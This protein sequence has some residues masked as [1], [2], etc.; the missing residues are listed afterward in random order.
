VDRAA[1][2]T[3]APRKNGDKF[4]TQRDGPQDEQLAPNIA[5]LAAHGPCLFPCPLARL[6]RIPRGSAG[7]RIAIGRR[8]PGTRL[9]GSAGLRKSIERR[10]H[11][12]FLNWI[13]GGRSRRGAVRGSSRSRD[14]QGGPGGLDPFQCKNNISNVMERR[15]VTLSSKMKGRSSK[16]EGAGDHSIGM[17]RCRDR[18]LASPSRDRRIG[19]G[20]RQ[21]SG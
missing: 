9:S 4:R 7:W 13:G 17:V 6:S 21:R 19:V 1:G 3:E 18:P 14:R 15:K 11:G 10:S 20:R 8:H 16:T 5:R 2:T 12:S